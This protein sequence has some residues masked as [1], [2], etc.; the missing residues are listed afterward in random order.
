MRLDNFSG[1]LK[2]RRRLLDL[3]QAELGDRVGCTAATIRKLE[4]GERKPSRQ[5][6]ELLARALQVPESEKE[7]FLHL[8]RGGILDAPPMDFAQT[9]SHPPDNLP[10]PLTSLVDRLRDI[11][12]VTD[13]L[14]NPVVRWVTL[15]G[16]PGIGKT[17]LGIQSGRQISPLFPDGV[18][19]VD[20][21]EIEI[22]AYVLPALIRSI[23]TLDIPSTASLEQLGLKL[24]DQRVLLILDNFEHI[25]EAALELARL[26]KICAGLKVLATSRIPLHIYGEH[27]FLV[28]PLD[29][30]PARAGE[31]PESLL[32]YE[33]VQLFVERAS[34]H[35]RHFSVT[36]QNA[37][38]IIDICST[39]EGI[40]LALELAAASL[41]RM[42]LEELDEML[43]RMPE[44]NWI[45]QLSTPARDLPARQRTLENVVAWSYHLLSEPQQRLFCDLGVFSGWFDAPLV[46][47]V[48]LEGDL[49]S[50]GKARKVLNSLAE[51]SL[52]ERGVIGG[53]SCWRMLE[54]I[55][56]YA[57]MM[58]DPQRR[59]QLEARRARY[60]LEL[61]QKF[62]AREPV[63]EFAP[64]FEL[65]AGNLGG[66][67]KWAI[68]A[69]QAQIGFELA[70][71]LE[72]VWSAL[73]YF[74][75]GLNILRQLLALPVE[76]EP[77]LRANSLQK[78]ADLAWQQHDFE[79]GLDFA[80]QAAELGRRYGLPG[81]QALYLNRLGRI[82]IERGEFPHARQVLTECLALARADPQSLNPGSPLAQ[83][84]ELS[85]FEGK[86]DQAQSLLE[87]ALTLLPP[88]EVI[89]TAIATT[90]LAEIALHRG[91]VSRARQLLLQAS[92]IVSQHI[93]RTLVYLCALVGYLSQTK[94]DDRA[95]MVQAARFLGAIT[96]LAEQSGVNF[97][98]FYQ[99]LLARRS[100]L[101]QERLSPQ[102]WRAGYEEGRGWSRSDALA[103][104]HRLI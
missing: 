90:D 10:V 61:T 78:A 40:P 46:A 27:E 102:E 87:Q 59:E 21:S 2:Q 58:L 32:D 65:H 25:A 19:F 99:E 47:A 56:Q 91:D 57:R 70:G 73:G 42:S 5:L 39:L 76:V 104:A 28:P 62:T 81:K 36:A 67:F 44:A 16:P 37:R 6:A 75:E 63:P 72:I 4:A 66:V 13:L 9:P 96:A 30:P 12:A 79:T 34:Q 94:A 48:C 101:I 55:H 97:S 103:Q 93:R 82:Y 23:T 7:T 24:K 92:G 1:W 71:Y 38:T 20:L 49:N 84:G 8:A 26:L 69:K 35:Q 43:H 3:T 77:L 52:L 53:V 98:G 88:D 95:I 15:I 80:R 74:R 89:F 50:P 51:H 29:V 14:A 54:V 11:E 100:S 64:F 33:A 85:F 86:L 17:R 45:A 83:L 68:A 18:W 22:A 31:R 41:K 60:F